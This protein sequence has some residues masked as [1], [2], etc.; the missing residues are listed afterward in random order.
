M[1]GIL[2]LNAP[3]SDVPVVV[4]VALARVVLAVASLTPNTALTLQPL[5]AVEVV[6]TKRT[7]VCAEANMYVTQEPVVVEEHAVL[8]PSKESG[9]TIVAS[10]VAAGA[11]HV[12]SPLQKVEEDA[13]V[14]LL[15]F[16][17]G[18]LPVTSK[19]R[20][21]EAQVGAALSLSVRGN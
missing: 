11:D 10:E 12:P 13:P 17:T 15:R 14:P 19:A 8:F 5:G 21:T 1:A 7:S 2:T 20:L 4:G 9:F 16:P 18:R 6:T 3:E